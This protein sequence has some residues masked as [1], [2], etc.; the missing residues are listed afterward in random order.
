MAQNIETESRL[1]HA[2]DDPYAYLTTTGRRTGQPHRI[3]IW[4][5]VEDGRIYLLAG[6]RDRSDWVR[7]LQANPRVTIELGGETHA[8]AARILEPDT[9]EDR[10]A[11]ELLVAKYRTGAD[12]LVNWGRTSLPVIIEFPEE[13]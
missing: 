5:A 11:R 13:E 12:S 3:E 4:F 2:A 7:N 9:V 10:R 6:G 1:R 8:G